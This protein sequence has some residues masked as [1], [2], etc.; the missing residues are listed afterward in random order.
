MERLEGDAQITVHD[1]WRGISPAFLPHVFERFRQED[2][3]VTREAVGPVSA[4]RL[5]NTWRR[6][7]EARLLRTA[8][9]PGAARRF[10]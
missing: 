7:T 4:S 9:V 8:T 6:H 10:W 1:T 2:A 5:R 3:S